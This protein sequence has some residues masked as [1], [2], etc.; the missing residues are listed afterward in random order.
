MK[1]EYQKSCPEY[2][3]VDLCDEIAECC[4]TR[5]RIN[6]DLQTKIEERKKEME[7][8]GEIHEEDIRRVRSY[9]RFL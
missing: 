5:N 9:A 3:Q 7:C 4:R 6:R 2:K 1:C 8:C